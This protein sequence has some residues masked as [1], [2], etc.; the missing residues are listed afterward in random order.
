MT[1]ALTQDEFERFFHSIIQ[2]IPMAPL[3]QEI[4]EIIDSSVQRNFQLGG[5][6]N[7]D[8]DLKPIGGALKWVQSMRAKEQNGKTLLDS[9]QLASSITYQADERGVTVGIN[10]VYGAIHQFGGFAGKGKKIYITARPYLVI[11]AE[12]YVEIQQAVER[13]YARFF[14]S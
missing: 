11:Q 13:Y 2:S 5:R 7:Y 6:F 9:S 12:D 4:G 14:K 3:Y 8:N 1:T 10:K